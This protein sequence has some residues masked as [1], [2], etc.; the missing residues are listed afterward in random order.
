MTKKMTFS[1]VRTVIAGLVLQKEAAN[2][3]MGNFFLGQGPQRAWVRIKGQWIP[4]NEESTD[5]L[6]RERDCVFKELL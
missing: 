6:S 5:T 1:P 3:S 4:D 2:G